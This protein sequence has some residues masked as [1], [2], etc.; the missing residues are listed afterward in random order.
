[1]EKLNPWVRYGG[2]LYAHRTQRVFI[3][4]QP[5]RTWYVGSGLGL[6]KGPFATLAKAKAA[7]RYVK[8]EKRIRPLD[9]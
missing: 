4:Q 3:A 8:A 5:D 6:G 7:A 2:G 9:T 1:M